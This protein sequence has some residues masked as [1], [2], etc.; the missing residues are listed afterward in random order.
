[1]DPPYKTEFSSHNYGHRYHPVEIALAGRDLDKPPSS[2]SE[3]E[4]KE[5]INAAMQSNSR[6][7]VLSYR[8]K[9]YPR[10]KG[11]KELGEKNKA[12]LEKDVRMKHRYNVN[13]KYGE[14]SFPTEHLYVFRKQGK[15]VRM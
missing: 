6:K 11:I 5:L 15:R 7:L 8:D 13:V 12:S 14:N 9:S 3:G 10:P 4:V 2:V 1:M